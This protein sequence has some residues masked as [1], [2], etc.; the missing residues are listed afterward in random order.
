MIYTQR[1]EDYR[2]GKK[3]KEQ[4]AGELGQML[5][6]SLHCVYFGCACMYVP[7]RLW[8]TTRVCSVEYPAF[9]AAPFSNKEVS[10]WLKTLTKPLQSTGILQ[11]K[12][13]IHIRYSP[14]GK[15]QSLLKPME[16]RN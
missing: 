14:L 12:F 6:K 1:G 4:E 7:L 3:W 11:I 16:Q 2:K 5:T 15:S 8:Q 13:S 9:L 10:N